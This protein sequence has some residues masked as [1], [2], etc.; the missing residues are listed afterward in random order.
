MKPVDLIKAELSKKGWNV[1]EL[2]FEQPVH[3]QSSDREYR[4]AVVLAYRSYFLGIVDVPSVGIPLPEYAQQLYVDIALLD[5]PSVF[6]FLGGRFYRLESGGEIELDRPV[7]LTP[8]RAISYRAPEV[9]HAGTTDPRFVAPPPH[10]RPLAIRQLLAVSRTLDALTLGQKVALVEMPVGSGKT[11]VQ[12]TLV[13]KL[14]GSGLVK[15]AVV[16]APSVALVQQ[17][18]DQYQRGGLSVQMLS[19]GRDFHAQVVLITIAGWD[20]LR[21]EGHASVCEAELVILDEPHIFLS[22]LRIIALQ[23]LSPKLLVG[24]TAAPVLSVPFLG[25]TTYRYTLNQALGEL[26]APAGFEAYE[27]GSFATVQQGFPIIQSARVKGAVKV[28]LISA[29]SIGADSKISFDLRGTVDTAQCETHGVA[30]GDILVTAAGATRKIAY[31]DGTL[32]ERVIFASSLIRIR[33]V[34]PSVAPTLFEFLSSS[35]GLSILDRISYGNVQKHLSCAA[36]R[37]MLV[38]LPPGEVVAGA[39][40]L[41]EGEVQS[42]TKTESAK[43]L[44]VL[45]VL[46][47]EIIP[48]LE[49]LSKQVGSGAGNASSRDLA[50]KLNGLAALLGEKSIEEHVLDSFPSPIALAYRRFRDAR[51]NVFEQVLRLRDLAEACTFFV[52]NVFLIDYFR[53]LAGRGYAIR[54]KGARKAYTGY[55]MA[56]RID[57]VSELLTQA[58]QKGGADLFLAELSGFSS[59]RH[60]A[61]LLNEDLRNSLSHTAAAS[62][63]QQRAIMERFLPV[64]MS[65]LEGIKFLTG[66]RLSRIPAYYGKDGKLYR[67]IEVYGGVSPYIAEEEASSPDVDPSINQDHLVLISPDDTILNLHPLYQLVSNADT[68]HE[69]HICLFKQRKNDALQGESVQGSFAIDMAGGDYFKRMIPPSDP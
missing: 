4:A 35:L 10:G 54:D 17:L 32:D 41:P 28:V 6:I 9:E 38:Y 50:S 25:N 36:L 59:F 67:R 69:S 5:I 58:D 1:D 49:E 27:L 37:K 45:N 68:R 24:F 19:S 52:Y 46:K 13:A 48:V 29:R 60:T 8:E 53:N 40:K 65:Y 7:D 11:S 51:F 47:T 3:A 64:V 57:F 16:V 34:D 2:I 62:E 20:A 44:A 18:A 33:A 23:G 56:A 63:S 14:L 39:G 31:V 22:P 21:R 55:S 66:Y 26:P 61:H 43:E 12:I 30:K 42:L 15:R